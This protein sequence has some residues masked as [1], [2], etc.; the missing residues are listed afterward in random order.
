MID[1]ICLHLEN[2]SIINYACL[3][4]VVPLLD[5]ACEY[6]QTL[7]INFQFYTVSVFK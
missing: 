4:S 7:P 3:K 1:N 5:W 2:S 6:K